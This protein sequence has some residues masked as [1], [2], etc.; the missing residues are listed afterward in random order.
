MN[1]SYSKWSD[2]RAKGRAAD[3][4]TPAER[5]AGK[6]LAK[7]R[8]EAY[9][10]GHQLAEMRQAACIAATC[11]PAFRHW[12]PGRHRAP[13]WSSTTAPSSTRSH[14]A[15][16][17]SSPTPSAAWVP[18]GYPASPPA[19]CPG[20]RCEPSTTRCA[21]WLAMATQSPPPTATEHGCN[22]FLDHLTET[23]AVAA[24]ANEHVAD[25]DHRPV[26]GH[27]EVPASEHHR[28]ASSPPDP[29][30]R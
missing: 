19:S 9:I 18:G 14:R 25:G 21:S 17:S 2:V 28:E 27:V 3:S 13:R 8:Q 20:L 11:S 5:A 26:D 22:G 10:R 4:R 29:G 30:E 23:A 1:D 12:Q 7:E 15:I 16:E 24:G 6:A